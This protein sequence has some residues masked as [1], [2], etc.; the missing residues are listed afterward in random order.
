MDASN[1]LN[2]LDLV[3]EA[4]LVD[5]VSTRVELSQALELCRRRLH[6]LSTMYCMCE[7]FY[8]LLHLI[9][10]RG[11]GHVILST[12]QEWINVIDMLVRHIRLCEE[13]LRT[14]VPVTFP[15]ADPTFLSASTGRERE[16]GAHRAPQLQAYRQM[17]ADHG[18]LGDLLFLNE[19]E[20][21][22][23]DRVFQREIIRDEHFAAQGMGGDFPEWEQWHRDDARA[24]GLEWTAPTPNPYVSQHPPGSVRVW[25]APV[26]AADLEGEDELACGICRED[27]EVG[28]SW[29]KLLCKHRFHR[30]C[31][32]PWLQ[33]YANGQ[34]CPFFCARRA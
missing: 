25:V 31:V 1:I 33:E 22:L 29:A 2:M 14:G 8:G 28:E 3:D 24:V 17:I 9:F 16:L 11:A 30:D 26:K 23:M 21:A 19:Q 10:L 12:H 6:D 7:T 4:S 15:I 32:V 18:S 20:Q 34:V 27:F 13:A 5:N